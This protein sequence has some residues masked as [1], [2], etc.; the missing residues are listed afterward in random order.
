MLQLLTSAIKRQGQGAEGRDTVSCG[1]S[2]R[3]K[4]GSFPLPDNSNQ[5]LQHRA[6]QPSFSLQNW[7]WGVVGWITEP[8]CYA[9][10]APT[11]T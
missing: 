3:S 10:L 2:P 5:K 6:A 4:A 8:L 7:G 1:A 9:D 11:K